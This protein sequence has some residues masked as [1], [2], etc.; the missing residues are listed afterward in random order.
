MSLFSQ[1]ER[2][3]L[4]TFSIN[5]MMMLQLMACGGGGGGGGGNAT[6]SV[7]PPAM[8]CGQLATND[9]CKNIQVDG[10]S[11]RFFLF[12]E[13]AGRQDLAPI[14]VFLHGGGGISSPTSIN[15][16]TDGKTFSDDTGYL[17]VFPVGGGN[18]GWSSELTDTA[19]IS[20]DSQFISAI[21]DQLVSENQADPDRVYVIG[22]SGGSFMVYQ[23]ACEISD[24]IKAG[25]ALSGQIRGDL[26]ACNP[27]FPV[28]IHHIHGTNDMDTPIVGDSNITSLQDTLDLW[29]QINSCDGTTTNSAE[30]S[31]TEDTNMATT[32]SYNECAQP[33]LYTS[34]SGGNHNQRYDPAVLHSLMQEL[35]Q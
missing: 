35:F 9:Q 22:Y 7:P 4:S 14:V 5:V 34:V 13:P 3:I 17:S 33:L 19:E 18:W 31:L 12:H 27:A 15:N 26:Q 32:A 25:V 20:E 10:F 11:E 24:K 6:G 8:P 28:A 29:S 23:L 16:N 2:S 1:K 30:F 21:I